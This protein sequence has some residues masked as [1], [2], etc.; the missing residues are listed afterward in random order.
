MDELDHVEDFKPDSLAFL[1]LR[2]LELA[3]RN[4]HGGEDVL[5]LAERYFTWIIRNEEI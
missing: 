2:C 3:D 5:E 4:T 1:K